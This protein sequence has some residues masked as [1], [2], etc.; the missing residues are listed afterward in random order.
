[1]ALLLA[2]GFATRLAALLLGIAVLA[3]LAKP[4]PVQQL[5]FAGH[6]GGC[7]AIVLVGAG[8]FSIDA[9]RYGRRVIR[10]QTTTPD[11]GAKD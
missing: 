2:L 8:A 4:G 11:R 7:M 1:M 9:R 3:M 5:L 6:V 10:L